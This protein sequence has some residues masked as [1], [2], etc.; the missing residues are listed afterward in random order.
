VKESKRETALKSELRTIVV[1]GITLITGWLVLTAAVDPVWGNT[2]LAI[3]SDFDE[4][5][6]VRQ[7]QPGVDYFPDKVDVTEAVGFSVSY[8]GHYKQVQ[9]QRPWREA[10][11][12]YH[13]L[14]T[15][16]G[17]PVPDGM[18][19]VPRISIPVRRAVSTTTT[20]LSFFD[21]LGLIDRLVGVG[22]WRHV[23]HPVIQDRIDQNQLRTIGDGNH[24]DPEILLTLE[25]DL[26][27]VYGISDI[28]KGRFAKL[29]E[30]GIPLVVIADYMETEPLGRA[31]WIK[32]LSLFFN[33]EKEATERFLQVSA[34]YRRLRALARDVDRRPTVFTGNEFKGTWYVPGGQS[35]LA[36]LLKDAGAD[37]L[38][39]TDSSIGSLPLDFEYVLARTGEA[40]YWLH[41]GSARSKAELLAENPRYGLFP[42]L[43]HGKV[44][45]NNAR[46]N[47]FGG[48]DFFETG[49]AEPHRVLADLIF[50]FHPH[51]LPNHRLIWYRPLH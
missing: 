37:Y 28:E 12:G 46:L 26:L 25:P 22:D 14:L 44:F 36:V 34:E 29:R 32:F 23:Y 6:C 27:L 8:H 17:T 47:R 20:T 2:R 33:R 21:R 31:E 13:Y 38:W 30:I 39:R 19:A 50:I 15:Q 3:P 51:L 43:T 7:F 24:L 35:Y 16:C 41:P 9:I 48:N 1:Q 18:T 5:G 42:V 45:N 4:Q 40:D 10:A 49:V 11:E